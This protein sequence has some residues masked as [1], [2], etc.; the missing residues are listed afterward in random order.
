M[1]GGGNAA[2]MNNGPFWPHAVKASGMAITAIMVVRDK[3]NM[4]FT[5]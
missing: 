5:G 1:I 2:G 4:G 3:S